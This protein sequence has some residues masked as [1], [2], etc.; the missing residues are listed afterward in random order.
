MRKYKN[1][2]FYLDT[3]QAFGYD[4]LFYVFLGGRGCREDMQ[5]GTEVLSK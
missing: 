2:S 3:T 4:A 1:T 5:C